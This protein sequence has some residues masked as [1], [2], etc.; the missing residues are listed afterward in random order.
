MKSTYCITKNWL[1]KTIFIISDIANKIDGF[2]VS[3][4]R[5]KVLTVFPELAGKLDNKYC[6]L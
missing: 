5:N 4:E 2:E 3:F 1:S 6:R